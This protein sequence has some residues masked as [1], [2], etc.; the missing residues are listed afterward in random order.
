MNTTTNP[1]ELHIT[2]FSDYI[3]PFCYIGSNRV[4]RLNKKFNLKINWCGLEIHPE[5]PPEGMPVYELGYPSEQ[6]QQMMQ[7]LQQLAA[8]ENI[9]I[10]PQN[11]T[12]NSHKALLLA[13]AAKSCGR[14]IFY[15]LHNELFHAYFCLGVNIGDEKELRT[16]ACDSGIPEAIIDDAWANEKFE[17]RLNLNY[18]AAKKFGVSGT[19]TF[20]IGDNVISGAVPYQQLLSRF[21]YP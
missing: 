13:D 9:D 12:T 4:L 20:I 18:Q 14:E 3:C 16:I 2:V 8:D 7:S 6:W 15:R 21:P 5:T 11:F 19:P 10:K 17:N 1:P